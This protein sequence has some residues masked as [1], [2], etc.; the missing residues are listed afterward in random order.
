MIKVNLQMADGS[1]LKEVYIFTNKDL[2]DSV[3][4]NKDEIVELF[5]GNKRI[6]FSGSHIQGGLIQQKITYYEFVDDTEDVENKL[7]DFVNS[8]STI[9]DKTDMVG[10]IMDYRTEI[11]KIIR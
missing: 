1:E 10:F 8:L 2:G 5:K 3:I 7:T 11:L 9:Y 6:Y 4:N